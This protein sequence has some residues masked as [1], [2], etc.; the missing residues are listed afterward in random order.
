M[1]RLLLLLFLAFALAGCSSEEREQAKGVVN[2]PGYQLDT[3]HPARN[4]Y[5]RVKMLVL[6]YTAGD[7]DVSLATLTGAQVSAHYLIP[8]SPAIQEGRPRIYQLVQE[9]DLAW[10]A[11]SSYWR[12]ATRINDTSIGIELENPGWQK[13]DGEKSYAP[14]ARAQIDALIPLMKDIIARYHIAPQNVVGHADVAPQ[15]KDDPGAMFPWLQLAQQG[16]G[17]WP[18][19]SRVAFYLNGRAPDT[20][21]AR[22]TLLDLL[23]RYGYDVKPGMTA[24]QQKRVIMAFQMHFRPARWDGNADAE[25]LAIAQALL[26]K[27]GQD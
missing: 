4:A 24:Q 7:F 2:K 12:G 18:D 25:T 5:P 11:G 3:L 19:N 13:N 21:V 8:A 27:Y 15:R 14:F 23:E 17:A 10:H 9:R 1:R 6:H 16:I 26:E 20:P 22:T